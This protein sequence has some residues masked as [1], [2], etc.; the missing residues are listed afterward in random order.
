MKDYIYAFAGAIAGE[1]MHLLMMPSRFY[2]TWRM[3]RMTR[4]IMY[5]AHHAKNIDEAR[6]GTREI[7]AE[8]MSDVL[9]ISIEE[10]RK[11]AKTA[12]IK[13][14]PVDKEKT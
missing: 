1:I 3:V 12:K 4:Q 9:G 8:S 7:I 2:R 5:L 14:E 10:A 6:A 11:F 13:V